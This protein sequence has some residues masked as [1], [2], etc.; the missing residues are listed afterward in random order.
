MINFFKII[1]IKKNKPVF[2]YSGGLTRLRGI[3]ELIQAM[4]FLRNK[5]ELWLL[6]RWES[7][8]FKNECEIMRGWEKTKYIGYIPYGEHFSYMKIADIGLVN[9]LPSPNHTPA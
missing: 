3:A 7:E 6:G 8:G 1:E 5:A 2:I 9:F 4:E